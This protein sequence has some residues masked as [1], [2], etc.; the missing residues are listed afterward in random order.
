VAQHGVAAPDRTSAADSTSGA[1]PHDFID[2]PLSNAIAPGKM[3]IAPGPFSCK[4][5][6]QETK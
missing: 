2:A 3:I 6:V 5:L 4:R 1:A